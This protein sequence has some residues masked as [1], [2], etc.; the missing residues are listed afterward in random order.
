MA[1]PILVSNLTSGSAY[2]CS[3]QAQNAS[4]LSLIP[5]TCPISSCSATPSASTAPSQ[6]TSLTA[7]AGYLQVSLAFTPPTNTGGSPITGYVA[8]CTSQTAGASTGT[9][10]GTSSPI[11][12][13]G[14]TGGAKYICSVVAQNINGN[15]AAATA[16]STPL[17]PTA[18]SAPTLTYLYNENSNGQAFLAPLFT[19]PSDTGGV[20]LTQYLGTCIST[21]ATT[22]ITLTGNVAAP[23]SGL[24]ITGSAGTSGGYIYTCTVQA[25]NSAGLVSPA[26]NAMTASPTS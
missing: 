5:S 12:V 1:S 3:I 17:T 7:T 18:P 14:L 21:N 15:S 25:K 4:G 23:A 24:I 2:T 13:S 11:L 8:S 16:V 10:N 26:S 9:A 19:A 6:P 22:T 20:A